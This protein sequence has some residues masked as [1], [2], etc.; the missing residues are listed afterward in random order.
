MHRQEGQRIAQDE[1]RVKASVKIAVNAESG[2]PHIILQRFDR[3]MVPA[4]AMRYDSRHK[5]RQINL[6]NFHQ[7]YCLS[8]SVQYVNQE[9]KRIGGERGNTRLV[10]VRKG[11]TMPDWNGLVVWSLDSGCCGSQQSARVEHCRRKGGHKV[12]TVTLPIPENYHKK[13]VSEILGIV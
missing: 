3:V 8:R 12:T 2:I 5:G 9:W 10:D 7:I 1:G 11:I 6:F 4:S 13:T